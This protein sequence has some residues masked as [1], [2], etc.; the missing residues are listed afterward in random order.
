M[1]EELKVFMKAELEMNL[2]KVV[3]EKL[4]CKIVKGIFMPANAGVAS[5]CGSFFLQWKENVFEFTGTQG[6]YPPECELIA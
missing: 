5:A 4:G 6:F 1:L 2:S 3:C